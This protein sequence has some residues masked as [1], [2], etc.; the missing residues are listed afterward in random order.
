MGAAENRMEIEAAECLTGEPAELTGTAEPAV[1][2][3]MDEDEE[4]YE[5]MMAT[6]PP[7]MDDLYAEYLLSRIRKANENY[8]RMK[9]WYAR[10]L[11]K[12]EKKRSQIVE[13]AESGLRAYFET[14]P[15]KRSRTQQ[16]YELPGGKLV[17]KRQEPEYDRQDEEIVRWL[18]DSGKQNLI[19][20]KESPDWGTLKKEL[21]V[22]PDGRSL[23]TEDG[24]IV[25]GIRVTQR[26]DRFVVSLK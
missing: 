8:E 14:V 18:R 25:P 13:W 26:D 10:M 20:V 24:E 11:E 2:E 15:R 4:E 17:L 6:E 21:K 3:A 1:D 22:S 5:E 16:S 23:V 9:D 12:I 7:V 19:R